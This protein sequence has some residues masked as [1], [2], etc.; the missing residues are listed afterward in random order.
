[1]MLIYAAV[2]FALGA[3]GGLVLALRAFKGQ[4]LPLPLALGH[5][6]LGAAGLVLL[7]VGALTGSGS[8]TARIA[9]AVLVIAALGGF[10]LL[11]FHLRKQQHP[12]AVIG[13]HALLAV[14]GF[15]TLLVAIL[16]LQA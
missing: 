15:A 7:I 14:A 9:L 12:K 2:L 11:S 16:Q 4:A 8:Q 13:L 3:L 5:G 6:V 1:M 10:Y